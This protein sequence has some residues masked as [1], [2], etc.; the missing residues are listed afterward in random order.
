MEMQAT[1][2]PRIALPKVSARMALEPTESW[3]ARGIHDRALSVHQFLENALYRVEK[4]LAVAEHA[5]FTL[6]GGI[7]QLQSIRYG[8]FK[9]WQQLQSQCCTAARMGRDLLDRPVEHFRAEFEEDPY[10]TLRAAAR[11][12][13]KLGDDE[14]KS[15]K[16]ILKMRW[17][18]E[19]T[20]IGMR[21]ET[22]MLYLFACDEVMEFMQEINAM[23]EE[24]D[25]EARLAHCLN[26]LVVSEDEE[27]VPAKKGPV[28]PLM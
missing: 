27:A 5:D 24:I 9:N 18:S 21:L 26:L 15:S 28:C 25:E 23:K 8:I 20:K 10:P 13:W 19:K 3:F 7:F 6:P 11:L 17:D 22:Q 14:T 16:R 4:F 1:N 2:P 12:C